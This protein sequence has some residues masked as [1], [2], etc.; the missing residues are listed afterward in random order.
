MLHNGSAS[1][2]QT[3]SAGSIPAIRSKNRDRIC[4][5]IPM[6]YK[7]KDDMY[8]RQEFHRNKNHDLMWE[9]LIESKCMDCNISDPRV[10]EFDHRPDENKMFNISKSVAGSTRGWI[11]IKKEIDKCDIVCSNCHKIRTMTRGNYKRYVSYNTPL[12]FNG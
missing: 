9:I 12:Q 10:L 4:Y 2:F 6:P 1:V 5:N 8:K 7:N 11:S 3:D